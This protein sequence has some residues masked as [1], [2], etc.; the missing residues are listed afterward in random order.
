MCSYPSSS[1]ILAIS[2]EADAEYSAD[3]AQS[4]LQSQA[5][6]LG[7]SADSVKAVSGIG[8]AAFE[9]TQAGS[10]TLGIVSGTAYIAVIGAPGASAAE[11]VA[12]LYLG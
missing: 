10:T 7:L 1:G 9:F 4:A 2:R 11:A 5:Q 3:T 8:D 6:A 12:K